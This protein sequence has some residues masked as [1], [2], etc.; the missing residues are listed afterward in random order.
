MTG[1]LGSVAKTVGEGVAEGAAIVG[2]GMIRMLVRV[3]KI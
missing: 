1:V 2:A 3:L